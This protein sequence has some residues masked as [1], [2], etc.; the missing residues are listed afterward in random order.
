MSMSS[1]SQKPIETLVGH[2]SQPLFWAPKMEMRDP[3]VGW[4]VRL[5]VSVNSGFDWKSLSG[6]LQRRLSS[7]YQL[8]AYIALAKDLSLIPSTYME[9]QPFVP[10]VPGVLMLFPVLSQHQSGMWCTCIH[11]CKIN[12]Y[13]WNK[14]KHKR[15]TLSLK[16]SQWIEWVIKDGSQQ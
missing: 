2:D 13:T 9:A 10:P 11:S 6:Q 8:R 14:S 15:Q 1:D 16:M 4:L 3:R 7:S 12:S 5:A